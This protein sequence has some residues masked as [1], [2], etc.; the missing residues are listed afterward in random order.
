[1]K[2]HLNYFITVDEC[3]NDKIVFDKFK[4]KIIFCE[5]LETSIGID[6]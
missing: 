6:K 1:M 5:M 2:Q 3:R 4:K